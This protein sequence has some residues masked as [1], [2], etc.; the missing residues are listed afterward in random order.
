MN[1]LSAT[2]GVIV[3]ALTVIIASKVIDVFVEIQAP[4]PPPVKSNFAL[5]VNISN[6]ATIRWN[7]FP[8]TVYIDTSFLD[9]SNKGYANNVRDAMRNWESS[10]SNLVTF[11]EITNPDADITIE[12]VSKLSEKSLDTIGDTKL[13]FVNV[14]NV[15]I[16]HDA[17]IELL[18]KSGSKKLNSNDMINLALH[19]IGHALGLEH[20]EDETNIMYPVLTVPSDKVIQISNNEKQIL[21]NTYKIQ[22]K[23]DLS[24]IEVNVTKST[25]KRLVQTFYLLNISMTIENRGWLDISSTEMVIKTDGKVVK[26]EMLNNMPVGNKLTIIYGNLYVKDDF[27]NVEI[28]LDPDNAIDEL[29]EGNNAAMVK[30]Q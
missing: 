6:N 25:V 4:P 5:L 12:W 7:H 22:P 19:E 2:L 3:L 20:A 18:I 30:I 15:G 27:S 9:E 16:I 21:Q 26:T 29:D 10:T 1:L 8:L 14:S 17:K 23:A 28:V 13:T 24:V 11:Q